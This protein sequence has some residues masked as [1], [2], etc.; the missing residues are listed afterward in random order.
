M[1][2]SLQAFIVGIGIFV[3]TDPRFISWLNGKPKRGRA[4]AKQVV[5][6]RRR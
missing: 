4:A 1:D 6:L 2:T 3:I 5:P